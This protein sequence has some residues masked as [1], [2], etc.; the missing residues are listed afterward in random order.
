MMQDINNSPTQPLRHTWLH[1]SMN[2]LERSH[3]THTHTHTHNV[4]PTSQCIH[5]VKPT[6]VELSGCTQRER[7]AQYTTK[8]ALRHYRLQRIVQLSSI[9]AVSAWQMFTVIKLRGHYQLFCPFI[10][11]RLFPLSCYDFLP[12]FMFI[13][14]PSCLLPGFL[15][16]HISERGATV[17]SLSTRAELIPICSTAQRSL[18]CDKL[19]IYPVPNG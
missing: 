6:L 8:G 7:R 2:T 18:F 1:K 13:L 16:V 11:L 12:S 15:S 9:T 19:Q 5:S 14:L 17:L 10:S 4:K 3:G